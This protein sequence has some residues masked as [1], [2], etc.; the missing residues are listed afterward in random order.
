MTD[1]EI[2]DEFD[3]NITQKF[4]DLGVKQAHCFIF[5]IHPQRPSYMIYIVG[6]RSEN[7]N[8]RKLTGH[9]LFSEEVR[10]FTALKR[11]GADVNYAE[12]LNKTDA[13]FFLYK[14]WIVFKMPGKYSPFLFE[15]S[16]KQAYLEKHICPRIGH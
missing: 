8:C 12:Y 15:D 14:N 9:M 11:A 10:I 3:E 5:Q 7:T 16:D 13:R 4:H 2:H 6:K 1:F